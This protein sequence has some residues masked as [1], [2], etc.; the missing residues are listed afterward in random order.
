MRI[1]ILILGF[2]GLMCKYSLFSDGLPEV[3]GA[4]VVTPEPQVDNDLRVL[5]LLGFYLG[6][7]IWGRRRRPRAC[8]E[9]Q[10][11]ALRH[12]RTIL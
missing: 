1:E 6:F 10:S 9:M 4:V 2:K 12:N 11:C 8:A 3:F 5:S 7:I